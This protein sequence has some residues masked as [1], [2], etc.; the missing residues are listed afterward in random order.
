LPNTQRYI[1][2]NEELRETTDTAVP[3]AVEIC[4]T[5]Y[6][7]DEGSGYG[8]VVQD[9]IYEVYDEFCSY[10]I[11]DWSVIDTFTVTGSDLD[12]YWPELALEADQQT[13]EGEAEYVVF[14]DAGGESHRYY[15]DDE[16]E[17]TRFIPGST[18][19]IEV[20]QLGGVSVL[21]PDR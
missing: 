10:T 15:P 21:E 19:I 1:R 5:P 8:E 9:C 2:C 4:G 18:W 3:G 6:T 17:F 14:F 16:V 20:N 13:G 7:I 12:P 11:M